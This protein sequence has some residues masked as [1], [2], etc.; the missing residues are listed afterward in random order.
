MNA[1]RKQ[2]T[3]KVTASTIG[4]RIMGPGC[5]QIWQAVPTPSTLSTVLTYNPGSC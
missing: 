1:N 2:T 3:V 4:T 5:Y